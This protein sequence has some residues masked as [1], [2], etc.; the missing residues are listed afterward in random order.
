MGWGNTLDKGE[1]GEKE[2]G[3]LWKDVW[4]PG[5]SRSVD[6]AQYQG[7]DTSVANPLT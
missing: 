5:A 3:A 7:N 1:F 6:S 2:T 4:L